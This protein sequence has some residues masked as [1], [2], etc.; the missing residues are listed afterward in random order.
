MNLFQTTPDL[1]ES[2][3]PHELAHVRLAASRHFFETMPLWLQ[4]GIA[5]ST[6]SWFKRA[7]MARGLMAAR[8]AGTLISL[9]ELFQMREY[10]K[11]KA[12]DIFYG[13]SLAAVESL[14]KKGGK[15]QF[16]RFMAALEDKGASMALGEVYGLTPVNVEDMVLEWAS[17]HAP[18]QWGKTATAPRED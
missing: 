2:A 6:E 14:V 10:P 8:E 4:E 18:M 13:E 7:L 16:W 11:D 5:E 15:E 17:A 1:T 3:V 9:E 12:S